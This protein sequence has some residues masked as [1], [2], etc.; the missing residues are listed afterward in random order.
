MRY[1]EIAESDER[2]AQRR[3]LPF[4]ARQAHCA[5]TP[6]RPVLI[7][8]AFFFTAHGLHTHKPYN[9]FI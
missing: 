6:C 3:G 2:H 4:G 5:K 7:F 1:E 8:L 9:Y